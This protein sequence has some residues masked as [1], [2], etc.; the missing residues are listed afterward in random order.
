M[1][2]DIWF[3][4]IYNEETVYHVYE[5]KIMVN[6]KRVYLNGTDITEIINDINEKIIDKTYKTYPFA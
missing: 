5:N 3:D 6:G 4:P 1:V 2:L